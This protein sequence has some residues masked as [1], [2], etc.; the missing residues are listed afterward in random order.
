[1]RCAVCFSLFARDMLSLM[2][3]L[4]I[5]VVIVRSAGFRDSVAILLL[6]L[7]EEYGFS[8]GGR[9]QSSLITGFKGLPF[10]M[11]GSILYMGR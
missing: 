1:M 8:P 5:E 9:W 7:P 4:M 6:V 2:S 11:L 3:S 10:D